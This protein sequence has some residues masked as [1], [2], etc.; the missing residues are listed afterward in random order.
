[1]LKKVDIVIERCLFRMIMDL[2][3][4]H[5]D[6]LTKNSKKKKKLYQSIKVC[7]IQNLLYLYRSK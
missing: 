6:E 2:L 3:V 5:W 7:R 4:S 1:M